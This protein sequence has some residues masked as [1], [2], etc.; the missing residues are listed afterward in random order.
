VEATATILA[1]RDRIAPPTL[2]YAEPDEGLDLD[3]VPDGARPLRPNGDR[4]AVA[5]SNS[6]GFGGH[7]AVLCLGAAP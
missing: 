5:L 3:Y 7:N 2:G 1:L 6:F 4:P